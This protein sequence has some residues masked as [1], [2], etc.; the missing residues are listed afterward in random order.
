MATFVPV[1]I[2]N[3][4]L[5]G[6]FDWSVECDPL[7]D[8]VRSSMKCDNEDLDFIQIVNQTTY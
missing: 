1:T 7:W 4:N 6:Q 3:R 2:G 5:T 8:V